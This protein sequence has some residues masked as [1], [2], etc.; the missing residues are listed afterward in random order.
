MI[1]VLI[2]ALTACS[3][4]ALVWNHIDA[5]RPSQNTITEESI[6]IEKEAA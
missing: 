1:T 3:V 6:Q 5:Q 4:I 2:V